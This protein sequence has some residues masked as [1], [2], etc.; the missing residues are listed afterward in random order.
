M[1]LTKILFRQHLGW[2]TKMKWRGQKFRVLN[3]N[4]VVDHLSSA[5]IKVV[6]GVED[7]IG[8]P[9]SSDVSPV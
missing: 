3:D 7:I 6:N 8:I 4:G 9:V 1:R 5:G 2:H